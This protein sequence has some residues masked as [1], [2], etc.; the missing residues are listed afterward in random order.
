MIRIVGS[1][2]HPIFES[3]SEAVNRDIFA[4]QLLQYLPQCR[5]RERRSR[6]LPDKNMGIVRLAR[7][8]VQQ[9]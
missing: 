1:F 4:A 6:L 3:A 2:T 7:K 9:L 8:G 5:M